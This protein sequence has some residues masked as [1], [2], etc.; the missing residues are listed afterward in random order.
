MKSIVA[1][2]IPPKPKL[3]RGILVY[4]NTRDTN[5]S[6]YINIDKYLEK[7]FVHATQKDDNVKK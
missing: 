5:T 4:L 2:Y 1:H 6:Q 3:T 7:Y